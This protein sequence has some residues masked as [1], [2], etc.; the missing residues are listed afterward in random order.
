[1]THFAFPNV[2]VL[3]ADFI[4][5]GRYL[6]AAEPLENAYTPCVSIIINQAAVDRAVALLAHETASRSHQLYEKKDR[7]DKKYVGESMHLAYLLANLN[8]VR[9]LR[10]AWPHD[11]W[12]TGKIAIT[13]DQQPILQEV[14]H[15]AEFS[16]KLAAFLDET[17]A[18][19]LLI[20]PTAN[21]RP[22]HFSTCKMAHLPVF[23][24]EEFEQIPFP[25]NCAG[26]M[27]LTVL[28][29]EL[30]TLIHT[31][32]VPGP[33]P[34]NGLTVFNEDDAHRFFGREKVIETLYQK[35][36]RGYEHFGSQGA[37]RMLTVLGPSGSGKSS[38][39]RAGLVPR[40]KQQPLPDKKTPRVVVFTCGAHPLLN[41]ANAVAR[42]LESDSY[43]PEMI[44]RYET[45]L[46]Q[47]NAQGEW[48]GFADLIRQ[49]P[50][51]REQAV[52]LVADQCEEIYSLCNNDVERTTFLRV[53]LYAVTAAAPVISAILTLRSDFLEQTQ[54][55]PAFNN[56]IVSRSVL[57]PVMTRTNLRDAIEQPAK[58]A[59]YRFA[60]E[61]VERLITETDGNMGA[62]PLLE[63]TLS[64]LWEGMLRGVEPEAVLEK[65][66]G[67]GGALADRAEH[68]YEKLSA[69]EKYLAR[70]IFLNLICPA[71]DGVYSRKRI[72]LDEIAAYRQTPDSV[73]AIFRAFSEP[74]AR[75]LTLAVDADGSATVEITHEALISRWRRLQK[76]LELDREFHAWRE[77]LKTSLMQWE[78]SQNDDGALL[79]GRLLSE[80]EEWLNKRKNELTS[81]ECA[82]IIHSQRYFAQEN[83]R[84]KALYEKTQQSTLEAYHLTSRALFAAH[85]ELP[86]LLAAL[87]AGQLVRQI[88][89]PVETRRVVAG[90]LREIVYGIRETLRLQGH[91]APVRCLSF[92]PDGKWLVSGSYGGVIKI[93]DVQGGYERASMHG[94]AD[95]VRAICFSPDGKLAA[96]GGDDGMIKI[97]N[98]ATGQ[99]IMAISGQAQGMYALTFSQDGAILASGGANGT[100]FI[101]DARDFRELARLHGHDTPV[102]ALAF[103]PLTLNVLASGSNDATIRLWNL[104]RYKTERIFSDHQQSIF[105]LAFHPQGHLLASGSGDTSINIWDVEH[106]SPPY[107]MQG[108]LEAVNSLS[109][110]ANG[111]ILASASGDKTVKLWDIN[112]RRELLTLHGH[113]DEALALGFN[114]EG[115]LMASGGWDKTIKIW[116]V[117]RLL[118]RRAKVYG[119]GV[120]S[121]C[122]NPVRN[123]LASG[124]DDGSITVRDSASLHEIMR[125]R[126][127][128]DAV[129]CIAFSPDGRLFASGGDDA[130]IILWDAAANTQIAE[131]T[132][133]ADS[134]NSV[135]F[136]QDSRL[137][138]SGSSD[139]AVIVWDIDAGKELFTLAAQADAIWSICFSPDGK[140]L[141]T[142]SWR[143]DHTIAIWNIPQRRVIHTILIP[144][145]PPAK[146]GICMAM[147]PDGT[148]LAS[149]TNGNGAIMFWNMRTGQEI[150][151]LQGHSQTI[152]TLAFSPDGALLASGSE[153]NTIKLWNVADG[154]EIATLK[155]HSH[156]VRSVAFSP[157]G[158]WLASGSLDDTIKLWH[159]QEQ[160]DFEL[161]GLLAKGGDWI[162]RYLAYNPTVSK[163]DR[164]M[165]ESIREALNCS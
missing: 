63:F 99:E 131:L 148:L 22:N 25:E 124:H 116:N 41:L 128:A 95:I 100:I 53:L 122:F 114:I 83:A 147:H 94:H 91:R 159:L 32:F 71:K 142:A 13:P 26:K 12:C 61:F 79:H 11:I 40:I 110:H 43:S 5:C 77:R 46:K 72:A 18:D 44:H 133:H 24:L 81:S 86:A 162:R 65:V 92:S 29:H 97:W 125:L 105:C 149:G 129:R 112:E 20:A 74:Y 78:T 30:A 104:D 7:R 90:T 111:A 138:A 10:H 157:D 120:N 103:H 141:A 19:T 152:L 82:Y 156:D 38:V 60:P 50:E 161:D 8:C 123:Q 55:F 93:W 36:L 164:R 117:P 70:A 28:P 21:L 34:Y 84:W 56:A 66:G 33:N 54:T 1:M 154:Q 89:A 52:I 57:V 37:S 69:D 39:V 144:N 98:A 106:E 163:E 16:L 127:H 153:D 96:T 47:P 126:G 155:E 35:F 48:D 134:V 165:C 2:E 101:W 85:D 107:R 51:L 27:L 80:A 73:Q 23:S 58:L 17:N 87:K 108:H 118:P 109:F 9:R 3:N 136:S 119:N 102:F 139:H 137:L 76:W 151:T 6:A 67:V 113:D 49:S 115:S 130:A 135:A 31:L 4:G 140:L 160:C 121:L 132:G 150:R 42:L 143:N 45:R 88:D 62:L 15:E 59:G 145:W 158:A 75:L 146:S 14:G 68:I 64:L